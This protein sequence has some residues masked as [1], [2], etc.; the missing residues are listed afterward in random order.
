MTKKKTL[1]WIAIIVAVVILG[2]IAVVIG[3]K[4]SDPRENYHLKE[5]GE[6][7]YVF[8]PKDDPK[9]VNE[10]IERIYQKQE[11]NQFGDNRYAIYFLPGKYDD[12]IE[13]NVG[14]YTQVAGL[15][16]L[17]TDTSIGK[18]QSLARWLGDDG[19]HNATCNFWR[20]VEN[21]EMRSNTTWAVSQATDMR[22]VNVEGALF[23]HD[24]NGWCSGGFLSDANVTGMTDSGSQQQWLSRNCDWDY[25][26]GENWNLVFVGLEEG[27]AP[28]GTWPAKPF[29]NIEK[30]DV[31]R[32]KPFLVY[33]KKEG[34]GVFVP[35]LVK[36]ATGVQWKKGNPGKILPISEFFVAKPE[37]TVDEINEAL[38]SGKNL[39]FTPG[40]YEYDKPIEVVNENTVVLGMGLATIRNTKGNTEM[41]VHDKSGIVVA[42]LLFDA[43]M[44]KTDCMVQVLD[45][46]TDK[47]IPIQLSDIFCRVGGGDTLAPTQA[48]TCLIIDADDVVGDNFWLW[49]ADHGGQVAWDKNVAN[50]GLIVNGDNVTIYALM[51]EH[52]EQYQTIWNGNGG[53]VFMYQSEIPYDVPSQQQWMSHDG[54]VYGYSSFHV[55]DEV[56]SFY[57]AGL[58][59][60]LYNRDAIVALYS[61]MEVPDHEGV[62]VEHICNVLLTGNPGMI[63]IIN[64][65][66]HSV[67]KPSERHE[68]LE[69]ENG[70]MK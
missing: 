46:G 38:Q 26:L 15:G 4:K 36:D 5:F 20:S 61:A 2:G 12:S 49:R 18:L 57:A 32:E 1:I 67:M 47:E 16:V 7:V 42:G 69:Y 30:T 37:N 11:T 48:D 19:N 59:I 14:F 44:T 55:D 62:R 8:S 24:N 70:Q 63:H 54:T 51:V 66:G 17:P 3:I 60:Y 13:V 31:V 64:D 53:K 35:D 34:Y 58:G 6:N 10:I 33:D 21:L 22:R 41:I 52:F 56:T 23:L 68:I 43:G 29:T 9:K 50:T 27:D 45:E 65:S 28:K 39:L 25:W 40:I